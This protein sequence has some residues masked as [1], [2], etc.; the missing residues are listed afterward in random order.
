MN[1]GQNNQTLLE[2]SG[3]TKTFS[4]G[5]GGVQVLEGFSLSIDK[6]EFIAVQGTSGSG[7]TTLLLIA[8]GLLRPDSGT[9]T[10]LGQDMYALSPDRRARFRGENIGFVF[11]QY[12]LLP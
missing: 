8:G 5:E 11:Q 2:M 7:K 1:E 12:H 4:R 10:C 3:V 9:V 6:G